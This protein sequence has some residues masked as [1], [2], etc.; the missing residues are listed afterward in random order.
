MGART[1]AQ[2]RS[3]WEQFLIQIAVAVTYIHARVCFLGLIFVTVMEDVTFGGNWIRSP[4][5]LSVLSL[6]FL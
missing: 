4:Q 1:V 5:G 3:L 2:G 6:L